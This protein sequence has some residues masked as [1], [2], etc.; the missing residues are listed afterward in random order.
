MTFA[1]FLKVCQDWAAQGKHLSLSSFI[2]IV[3]VCLCP[4][5]PTFDLLLNFRV[6]CCRLWDLL[7]F[8]VVVSMISDIH[9]YFCLLVLDYFYYGFN[10]VTSH[11][12][13]GPQS[14]ERWD[15]KLLSCVRYGYVYYWAEIF[16]L[17]CINIS[18]LHKVFIINRQK[19]TTVY[20]L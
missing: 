4:L 16:S 6:C 3:E 10:S 13:Q 19:F 8:T 18:F 5:N 14:H 7:C 2:I 11:L 12:R 15:I 9:F 20:L 1:V 17:A